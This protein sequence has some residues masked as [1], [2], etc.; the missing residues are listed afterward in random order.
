MS[1]VFKKMEENAI[2]PSE[3]AEV[4]L[5]AVT[6]D[7]PQLRYTVGSDASKILTA[8]KNMSD[9]EFGNLIKDTFMLTEKANQ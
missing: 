5:G 9:K 2:P 6:S 1:A 8:R 7:E 3:V 4:I